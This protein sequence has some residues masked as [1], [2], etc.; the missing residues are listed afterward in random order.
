MIE[1]GLTVKPARKERKQ[2]GMLSR[3]KKKKRRREMYD[4][5]FLE[6]ISDDVTGEC[7]VWKS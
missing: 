5:G 6:R 3:K 1:Y 4:P 7:E 2:N